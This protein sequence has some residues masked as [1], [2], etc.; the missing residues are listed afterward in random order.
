MPADDGHDR[1]GQEIIRWHLIFPILLHQLI[2]MPAGLM[3]FKVRYR[4]DDG[5][6]HEAVVHAYD[7][8]TA[9]CRA[10]REGAVPS[11]ESIIKVWRIDPHN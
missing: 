5:K 7:E 6:E 11:L 9:R 4:G 8:E 3:A 1:E 10:N 2:I